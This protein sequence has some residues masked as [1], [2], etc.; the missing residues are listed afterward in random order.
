MEIDNK[1]IKLVP[2]TTVGGPPNTNLIPFHFM[3][4]GHK[5]SAGVGNFHPQSFIDFK[6]TKFFRAKL[7]VNHNHGKLKKLDDT[8]YRISINCD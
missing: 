3:F 7:I 2:N 4:R 1:T 8:P 5:F 6:S